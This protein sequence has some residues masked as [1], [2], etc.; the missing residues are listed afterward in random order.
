M[1]DVFN[2]MISTMFT[3][4]KIRITLE[5]K[6][7]VSV[8]SSLKGFQAILRLETRTTMIVGSKKK[9]QIDLK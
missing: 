2:Q 7:T 3:A 5:R 6:P 1:I 8:V 9:V 4:R